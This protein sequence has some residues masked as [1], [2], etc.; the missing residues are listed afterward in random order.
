M[1]SSRNKKLDALYQSATMQLSKIALKP[2]VRYVTIGRKL[3]RGKPTGESAVI[4]YVSRKK[5]KLSRKHRI[6]KHLFDRDQSAARPRKYKTDVVQLDGVPRAFGARS[7]HRLR[8]FDSDVG[9]CGVSFE[10]SGR[11]YLLTNAHVVRRLQQGGAVGRVRL[12]NRTSGRYE[13]VGPVVYATPLQPGATTSD[14]TAIVESESIIV[15]H[16]R[17]LDQQQQ[18]VALGSF[19]E[20]LDSTYWYSINGEAIWCDSPQPIVGT[21]NIVVDG[22][23]IPYTQFWQ[24][25]VV[26]GRV[27]PGHSGAAI[28]RSH[29]N[30]FV[31]CGLLFGGIEPNIVFAFPMIPLFNRAWAALA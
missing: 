22:V 8:A 19:S 16:M 15:D 14:D 23:V 28:L 1:S 13:D 18:I 20:S 12:F 30:G 9:T 7:G 5:R 4:V 29:V 17:V 21:C 25:R 10:K 11:G 31:A 27:G 3:R 26:R 24:L 6:P 2:N